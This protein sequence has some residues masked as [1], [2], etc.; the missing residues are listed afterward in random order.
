MLFNSYAFLLVFLPST[1]LIYHALR[2]SNFDRAAIGFL[3]FASL[4][5]Y[6][7]WN[8][9]Y[10]ILLGALILGNYAMVRWLIGTPAER[11]S[12]RRLALAIGVVSNLAILGYF[13]YANF[14]V[15]NVNAISGSRFFLPPII[16]PL[17]ISF[18]TF[19]K[20]ALIVDTYQGKLSSLN[21]LDYALFV[22]FFPQLIAGPIVHHSEVMPQFQ[23]RGSVGAEVIAQ[24]TVIFVIGLC[25]KV[26]LADTLAH[27]ASPPFDAAASGAVLSALGAWTGAIAY[28]LQLYFDF[29]GYSDMAIGAA[30]LFGI[31]L[32]LNF[33]SP[34][35]AD[36][37]IE[38]WRLWHMTLSRFLRDYLYIPL[39]GNRRGSI[40]RYVNVLV[41]MLLG[42]LWHG[43]GWTFVVWGGFHGLCLIVN[44][45]WQAFRMRVGGP[46]VLPNRLGRFAGGCLTFLVVVVGWVFF[47]ADN[48]NSAFKMLQAMAGMSS[49]TSP[50]DAIDSMSFLFIGVLLVF[51]WLTPNS[52]EF[53][54]YLPPSGGLKKEQ[55]DWPTYLRWRPSIAW[56]ICTGALFA[57]ALLS[58][59]KVS[60]FIYFQF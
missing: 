6:G 45:G 57:S 26:L 52:Q 54:G 8:P 19:Q 17:G 33:A 58:L 44:R 20:I 59:S 29:S 49:T 48:M 2:R 3:V 50:G 56:A 30:L 16:L 47:R 53:T 37:I 46:L 38:F 5:F 21:F 27:Y 60:E 39:G 34:Y 28:T 24:G 13:K 1:F 35:K 22:S 55:G 25:K 14:F 9:I 12:S 31:R 10:L 42:G 4:V 15:N 7:W 18:F 41:T 51:V 40:R 11:E 43:A 32:P 23:R 36:S